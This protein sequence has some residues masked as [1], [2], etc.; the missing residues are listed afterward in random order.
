MKC[1]EIDVILCSETYLD[2]R[3]S[4]SMIIKDY[5]IYRKD[6]NIFG[7]G[8]MIA[9]NKKYHSHYIEIDSKNFE[10][11]YC[12]LI[13]KNQKFLFMS[14][15]MSPIPTLTQINEFD[16]ILHN[17]Q[18]SYPN[19]KIII[20]GDLNINFLNHNNYLTKSLNNIFHSL[21]L[22]QLV[23]N[24]TYPSSPI[25]SSSNSLI[26]Y[27]I[28]NDKTIVEEVLVVDNIA[29]RCDHLAIFAKIKIFKSEKIVKNEVKC[30]LDINEKS[31][32]D[33]R[34][35]ICQIDWRSL[36]DG[37]TIENIYQSIYTNLDY[38]LKSS[39]K[40]KQIKQNNTVIPRS[41]QKLIKLKRHINSNLKGISNDYHFF[42]SNFLYQLISKK[43][44]QFHRNKF[45]KLIENSN[46][47]RK[48]YL[49]I[50]NNI[51][52]TKN[53]IT[54]K[55]ND[56]FI[57]NE[58]A[59]CDCFAKH[60]SDV[61]NVSSKPSMIRID[62]NV[63]NQNTLSDFSFSLTDV[64]RE[65]N[66]L[67]H[68]KSNGPSLIPTELLKNCSEIFCSIFFH[69]F[70]SII[71]FSEIPNQMKISTVFPVLKP[72]KPKNELKSYRPVSVSDN[73]SKTFES[74]IFAQLN[75]FITV[76]NVLPDN[77]YGFRTGISTAF[78][79]L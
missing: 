72:N 52:F 59:I 11:V 45:L 39:F 73:F 15:Y 23:S 16:K 21:K 61:Y 26:D 34:Q 20:S 58:K 47:Y 76:N 64:L 49:E 65:I 40:M 5:V 13:L 31:T 50:K 19:H 7:G 57:T 38:C 78:F 44:K 8:V 66:N 29:E 62:S 41:I 4:D 77:Q 18:N 30:I 6:R 28:T 79:I 32:D 60:F 9:V 74:L 54:I 2:N 63:S 48:L 12:S 10:S 53:K 35:K 14:S 37:N 22:Y 70:Q 71:Y 1:H 42:C 56:Q 17:I 24:P 46:N 43:L 51:K 67:D 55:T 3:F 27:F 25:H 69:L 68:K 36:C 75:T 33:F